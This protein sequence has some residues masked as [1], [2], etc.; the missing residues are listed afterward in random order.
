MIHKT[1]IR[2]QNQP[3]FPTTRFRPPSPPGG[4]KRR[5]LHDGGA[6]EA[7]DRADPE[8]L[9]GGWRLLQPRADDGSGPGRHR[10][11]LPAARNPQGRSRPGAGAQG[12]YAGTRRATRANGERGGASPYHQR[13]RWI[14]WVNV[15]YRA[16]DW[17]QVLL[18]GLV[19][20]C[21][22]ARWQALAHNMTR[23]VRSKV[24]NA[25]FPAWLR[26]A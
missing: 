18:R 16:R 11:V 24:L 2:H 10:A 9:A 4:T 15:G 12:R 1:G 20:I 3:P 26:P 13:A 8:E 25:A 7:A 14:E 22:K 6:G 17:R 5:A 21:T 23:I 19:K